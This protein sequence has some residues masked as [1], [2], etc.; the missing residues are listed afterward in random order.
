[1]IFALEH[2]ESFGEAK[3]ANLSKKSHLRTLS[4]CWGD[5]DDRSTNKEYND[6]HVL[7]GLEPHSNLE[8][9]AIENFAGDKFPSWMMV[10]SE[11]TTILRNLVKIKLENCNACE[12]IP[13]LGHLRHLKVAEIIKMDNVK[14]IGT[15]FYRKHTG[16]GDVSSNC[17]AVEVL[18]FPALRGLTLKKM[19]KLERWL[20]AVQRSGSTNVFP[21]LEKLKIKKCSRLITMPSHFPSVAELRILGID[22]ILALKGMSK[23]LTSLTF[24]NLDNVK[25]SEFQYVVVEF[26]GNN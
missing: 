5:P 24:L 2:V 7:E 16:G 25:G 17:W 18:I 21:C 26:L 22:N 14:V 13:L 6:E 3:H 8:G 9:L 19:P 12:R 11:A 10:E 15:K 1:M 23:K 20:E 4:L